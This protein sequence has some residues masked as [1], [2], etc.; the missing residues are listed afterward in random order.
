MT[1]R[2]VCVCYHKAA[3]DGSFLAKLIILRTI[4][5]SSVRCTE[6]L[7]NAHRLWLY[8]IYFIVQ[9]HLCIFYCRIFAAF[10]QHFNKAYDNDDLVKL[11]RK[12]HEQTLTQLIEKSISYT[13]IDNDTVLLAIFPLHMGSAGLVTSKSNQLQLLVTLK[14][15]YFLV[16]LLQNNKS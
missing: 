15:N 11:Y 9:P 10:C 2:C 7:T 14:S 13:C 3:S 4:T 12:Q 5:L 8:C 6:T 1:S 16:T